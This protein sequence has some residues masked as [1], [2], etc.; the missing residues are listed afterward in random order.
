MVNEIA[1][2]KGIHPG[3]VLERELKKRNLSKGRFAM[4]LGEYP[5]MIGDITKGKRKLSPRIALK[6]DKALDK[7]E[8]FFMVLQAYYDIEME[9]RKS[10]QIHHPDLSKF[11]PVLFWDTSLDRIDWEKQRKAVIKRV[12]ERGNQT[13][14]EE[15]SRFYGKDAVEKILY[16]TR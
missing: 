15:I 3:K 12:H 7:E 8:G 14:K 10:S 6:L 2:L 4:S 11:R 13:E 1:I 16:E 9:R 5:Q